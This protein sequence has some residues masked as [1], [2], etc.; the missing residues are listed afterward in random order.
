MLVR[1]MIARDIPAAAAI[2]RSSFGAEAHDADDLRLMLRHARIV[3]LVAEDDD[4][5]ILGFAVYRM[6]RHSLQIL[7]LAVIARR[8]GIGT[9]LLEA[10]KE[11][12]NG[13]SHIFVNVQDKNLAAHL[14]FKSCGYIATGVVK[15]AYEFTWS[16]SLSSSQSGTIN[17]E[18][19]SE[20]TR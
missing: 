17:M 20:L 12:R 18:A 1:Y 16:L 14:F 3:G 2:E 6:R 5:D 15:D 4:G 7:D 8:R 13:R 19:S 10:L 11:R 9:A